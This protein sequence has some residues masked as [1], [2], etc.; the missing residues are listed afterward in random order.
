MENGELGWKSKWGQGFPGWHI[1]CTAMA[2]ATLGKQLDVHTGGEDLMYTHHNGE[3]AQA[4]CATGRKYVTYW[5]HNAHVTINNDKLAKSAGNGLRLED[6]VDRGYS[7]L[8]YR[9]WL[10]QSHYRARA[11]FSFEALEASKQALLRLRHLVYEDLYGIQAT[12]VNAEYA[13]KLFTAMAQDLNTPQAL[14]HL[15]EV[16]KDKNLKPGE[17]LATIHLYDS[18]LGLGLA[19]EPDQGRTE[20]GF[21]EVSEIPAEIQQLLEEREIARVARNW[22]EADRIREVLT[23]R[24]YT[25]EDTSSGPRLSK[26]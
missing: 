26:L 1:E 8:D 25:I 15:W 13:Q 20:L 23:H 12:T 18:L 3:I 4:E 22:P 14:A 5:L 6:I 17:I 16:T 21:I 24:G 9:Y 2:F 19:K 11:N 10:L 7:P